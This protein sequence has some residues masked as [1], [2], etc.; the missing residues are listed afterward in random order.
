LPRSTP[1]SVGESS[2]VTTDGLRLRLSPI[3]SGLFDP[4]DL[5]FTPDGCILVAERDGRLRVVRAGR[6]LPEAAWTLPTRHS[7]Q[8]QLLAVAV[9]PDFERSRFVYA[10]YTSTGSRGGLAFSL[11]RLREV[12]DTLGDRIV[13]L[14]D[15]PASPWGPSASLRFGPD[16]KLFAA[17]DDGGAARLADDLSS[18]NGKILR[19][20]TDG[21]TPDDQA[22][23]I[24]FYS[25]TYP[26]P[27]G[28]G[29]Y[30]STGLL[31]AASQEG[32]SGR[33]S[34]IASERVRRRGVVRA[35]F[36][37]PA[38][39]VPSA[40][41]VYPNSGIAALRGNLLIA[42]DKGRH[43]LR[44]RVDPLQ[45]SHIV[46]TEPLLQDQIGG[47][48]SVAVGPDGAIYVGTARTIWR[49]SPS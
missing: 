34:V 8:E 27:R 26:S 31:W 25:S 14:D 35:A 32:A 49:L 23:N 45:P 37:L 38:G 20:N 21:T 24:P 36:T 4:V 40:M 44:V 16:G 5:A 3:V 47:V 39:T 28:L 1:S 18:S 30:L 7:D 9:D 33:L 29:W 19:L 46:G 17:F 12:A 42:S 48:Q 13:L 6:L 41:A 10:I 43:L 15:V 22:G 2:I 11:A